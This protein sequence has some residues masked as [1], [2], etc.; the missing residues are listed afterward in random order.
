MDRWSDSITGGAWEHQIGVVMVYTQ[1][2]SIYRIR[3]ELTLTVTV[4]L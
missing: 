3:Q 4:S 1:A 2:L